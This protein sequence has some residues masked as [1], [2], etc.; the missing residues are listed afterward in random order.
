[1]IDEAAA[2]DL[3]Q[4]QFPSAEVDRAETSHWMLSQVT[5]GW[6]PCSVTSAVKVRFVPLA[7][8]VTFQ[9]APFPLQG[10]PLAIPTLRVMGPPG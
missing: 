8:T 2:V 9:V 6:R 4:L 10:L 5:S 3:Q 1:M 7:V